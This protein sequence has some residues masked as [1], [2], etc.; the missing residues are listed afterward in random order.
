MA[1]KLKI[2]WKKSAIGYAQDQKD[3]IKALGFKKLYSQV[4]HNDTPQVRGMV[5]KVAHLVEVEEIS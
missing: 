3:T 1:G 5:R 2:T 4:V